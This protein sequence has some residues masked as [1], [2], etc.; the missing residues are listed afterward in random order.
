M[1]LF[2]ANLMK[3]FLPDVVAT[4]L[5]AVIGIPIALWLSNFQGNR[6]QKRRKEKILGLLREELLENIG[7][8]GRWDAGDKNFMIESIHLLI[9]IKAKHWD[10]FSDGGELQWINNPNL[11]GEIADA[12]NSL[13]MMKDLCDKYFVILPLQEYDQSKSSIT[14]IMSLIE[15]GVGQTITE[16][17]SAVEAINMAEKRLSDENWFASF[18]SD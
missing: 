15:S 11:L 7:T 16:I 17:E 13:R 18:A 4:L 12:Y 6:E 8:L 2:D 1:E 5:G 9:F 14:E 10:A 3:D